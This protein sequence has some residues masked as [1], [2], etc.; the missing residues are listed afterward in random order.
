[1]TALEVNRSIEEAR[2]YGRL[3]QQFPGAAGSV[4][5]GSGRKRI[6]MICICISGSLSDYSMFNAAIENIYFS[7]K[8]EC[9]VMDKVVVPADDRGYASRG[10]AWQR[11]L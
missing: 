3:Y 6:I 8:G 11:K 4:Q 1:M 9:M 2:E 7:L 10:H 5:Q